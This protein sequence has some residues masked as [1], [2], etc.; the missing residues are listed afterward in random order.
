MGRHNIW[1]QQFANY[2]HGVEL[3]V[4]WNASSAKQKVG[5]VVAHQYRARP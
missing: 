3:N 2:H 1:C 5:G 4:L